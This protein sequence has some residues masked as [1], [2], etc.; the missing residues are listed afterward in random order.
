M[1]PASPPETTVEIGALPRPLPTE[2]DAFVLAD[3]QALAA[4]PSL[5]DEGPA[6]LVLEGG[7]ECKT[8]ATLERVLRSL[9]KARIGRD[10]RLI[11]VGGGA[12]LDLG[13]LAASLYMRGIGLELVPTTLLAMCDA[14]IGGKTA[15]DLPE[16]KNL[17]GTFWPARRVRID[18]ELLATLPEEELVCGLAEVLKIA[19]GFDAAL[20]DLLERR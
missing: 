19:I 13:G 16:G 17:V 6:Q 1:A 8:L 7:E 15:V 4:H 11:A 12:V 9:A 3:A 10:G 20:L 2:P 5:L 18:V 14:S